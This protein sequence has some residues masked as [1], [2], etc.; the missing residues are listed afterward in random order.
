MSKKLT[1][2]EILDRLNTKYN[3]RYDYEIG[4]FN[5]VHDKKNIKLI[6]IPYYEF[7]NIENIIKENI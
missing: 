4:D 1:K 7:E 6:R 3:S 5:S 2:I